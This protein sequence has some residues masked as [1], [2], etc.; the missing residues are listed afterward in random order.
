MMDQTLQGK[1]VIITGAGSVTERR[2]SMGPVMA[3]ALH[4][5]GALV[6]GIDVNEDGLKRLDAMLNPSG[7]PKRF[8]PVVCDISSMEQCAAAVAQVT[9]ELGSP[10]ILINHAGISQV[11]AAPK[12]GM[13]QFRFWEADPDAWLLIQKVHSMGPFLLARLAVPGMLERKWGRIINTSSSFETMLDPYRSAYGPSKAAL[14]ASSAIWSKELAGTGVTVNCILPGGMV[15]SNS[16]G[17]R[18]APAD[19][20]LSPNIMAAP[21]LWL[22]SSAS[23]GVTGR[24]FVANL[25]DTKLSGA[26]NA[27]RQTDPIGWRG[28]GPGRTESVP[29]F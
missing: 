15:A 22:A 27:R 4:D 8:L 18:D 26:E 13:R 23:D 25:W 2:I 12:E 3:K 14:E 5:A 21:I 29:G 28:V 16:P 6:A 17:L 19:K 7:G 10:D 20:M 9:R 24:R 11:I 1:V